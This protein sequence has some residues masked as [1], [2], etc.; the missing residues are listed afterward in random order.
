MSDGKNSGIFSAAIGGGAGRSGRDSIDGERGFRSESWKAGP[1]ISLREVD[2]GSSDERASSSN[3]IRI[4]PSRRLMFSRGTKRRFSSTVG[5]VNRS[6]R[7]GRGR[8]RGAGRK[9]GLEIGRGRSGECARFAILDRIREIIS[10][11]EEGFLGS[12]VVNNN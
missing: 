4:S 3:P 5:R 6:A 9:G 10:C 11:Q 8:R 7:P 1:N 2:G 12:G